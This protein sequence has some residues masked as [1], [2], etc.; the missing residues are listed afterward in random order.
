MKSLRELIA[1]GYTVLCKLNL[2]RSIVSSDDVE[3]GYRLRNQL[4]STRLFICLLIFSIIILLVYTSQVPVTYTVTID[5]PTLEDYAS[6]YEKHSNTL[7]C[8]CT[9]IA[10]AQE[11]F[12]TLSPIFHQ[13]CHSDFIKNN[14]LSY[15][16]AASVYLL[17]SDF[18]VTG[19]LIFQILAS[20]CQLAQDTI[21]SSLPKFYSTRFISN[22]LLYEELL[23]NQSKS[24]IDLYIAVTAESFAYLFNLIR[25]TAFGNGLVS[26]LL[27]NFNFELTEYIPQFSGYRVIYKSKIYNHPYTCNC[28]VTPTC[29]SPVGIYDSTTRDVL[30]IIPGLYTGCLLVEAVRQSNLQCLYNQ[31]CLH[32]IDKFLQSPVTFHVTPLNT[33]ILSRYNQ[34]TNVSQVLGNLMI[35]SWIKNISYSSYYSECKPNQC[36]YTEIGKNN[37]VYIVTALLGLFG[38]LYKTLYFLVPILVKIIRRRRVSEDN[39]RF[40]EKLQNFVKKIIDF[41]RTLNLF[42]S[43]PPSADEYQLK[44]QRISTFTY[45]IMLLVSF[46]ILL[47]HSATQTITHTIIIDSPS[48]SEYQILYNQQGE[49]LSCSCSSITNEYEDFSWI[50]PIYHP[51]CTSDFVD[52]DWVNYDGSFRMDLTSYDFRYQA[53]LIFRTLASFCTLANNFVS[54]SLITFNS[55]EMVSIDLLS[56]NLFHEKV[57]Y[58]FTEF[59]Q[60]TTKAFSYDLNFIRLVIQS[61]LI[62]SGLNTDSVSYFHGTY[63]ALELGVQLLPYATCRCFS[64]TMCSMEASIYFYNGTH[65]LPIFTIPGFHIGCYIDDAIRKST[66]ECYFNQTC[67]DLMKFHLNYSKSFDTK[68]LNPNDIKT[69]NVTSAVDELFRNVMVEQWLSNKSYK[70]YYEKC[71]PTLCSHVLAIRTPFIVIITTL[72]GLIGGLIKVLRIIVPFVVRSL[73]HRR[74]VQDSQLHWSICLRYLLQKAIHRM[75]YLNLFRSYNVE[76]E[77]RLRNQLISTRLFICLLIFSVIIL[78]VYTS[79]V[80]VTYTV[81]IDQPTLEDYAS[82]Y[83]KHSNSLICP[84]TKIAIAQ[85]TFMTLTP[86][87]HQVCHSSFIDSRWRTG[88]ANTI[89]QAIYTYNRDFR[90]RGLSAFSALASVCS[91]A[92]IDIFNALLHFN[93]TT[94]IS[95]TLLSKSTLLAQANASLDLYVTSMAYSFS[96]SFGIIRDTIQGNGFISSTLSSITLRLILNNRTNTRGP[97]GSISPRYKTYNNGT[98]ICSCHDSATCIE[99]QYVYTTD[100]SKVPTYKIPGMV[101]GCFGFEAMLQTNLFCFFNQTCIDGLRKAINFHKNFSTEALNSSELIYFDVNSTIGSMM[102]KAMIEKWI[103]HVNYTNYYN[104]CHPIYC[105][106]TYVKQN[107]IIYVF[108][109]LFA[110]IGGLASIFQLL[111]PHFIKLVRYVMRKWRQRRVT[112]SL[113]N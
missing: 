79:Q 24:S 18:R 32:Q 65:I 57:Q 76:N 8:P 39:A 64:S 91:L 63:P 82:L 38:G 35:E 12:M 4:I 103:S 26:G 10:I 29:I 97:I 17:S 23:Y 110:L 33:S 72:I 99:Q 86:I 81:T 19:G 62:I 80:P 11:T 41:L 83:E 85:E 45:I 73:R 101:I 89:L 40:T 78:L 112:T 61:N 111:I 75:R 88:I 74:Q 22:E 56:E 48:F 54:N 70:N 84:C 58:F 25:D 90:L 15:L 108:T 105:K 106:Y 113:E 21:K 92:E 46:S 16:N 100:N 77:Y 66:L 95:N 42:S 6:L 93:S 34:T 96:R 1:T 28:S 60:S 2:Y 71:R 49:R 20:F 36:T 109:T 87:F 5:Q 37:A 55:T 50:K 52:D 44:T 30:F 67:V 14:W 31:T 102:E 51:V 107:D 43:S 69:H 13:V 104:Q 68:S 94:F 3:N 9:T 47:I 53:A 59:I 98:N 27:T 7:I